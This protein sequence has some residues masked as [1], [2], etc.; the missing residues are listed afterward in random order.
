MA[1]NKPT[2]Y[3]E[4]LLAQKRSGANSIVT[5]APV[6]PVAPEVDASLAELQRVADEAKKA[7][8]AKAYY[9]Q[10]R[11]AWAMPRF[12][13][14]HYLERIIALAEVCELDP[15]LCAVLRYTKEIQDASCKQEWT[16]ALTLSV[17]RDA[18][19][20]MLVQVGLESKYLRPMAWALDLQAL[21]EAELVDLRK[22]VQ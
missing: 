22:D 11:I 16:D 15:A 3:M 1:K 10:K 19:H 14:G 13:S 7:R 4:L 12:E 2:S 9:F 17:S 6:A 21:E 5:L 8:A 20:K 18:L